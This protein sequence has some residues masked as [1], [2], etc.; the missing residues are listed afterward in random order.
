[1]V[2]VYE[3]HTPQ[4]AD[5]NQWF[6]V[7]WLDRVSVMSESHCSHTLVSRQAEYPWRDAHLRP[8]P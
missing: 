8:G 5:S 4:T 1:M 6:L 2:C 7:Q 3:T